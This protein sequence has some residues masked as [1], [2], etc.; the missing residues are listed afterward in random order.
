MSLSKLFKLT[1]H[2]P[3][4]FVKPCSWPQLGER[5][6]QTDDNPVYQIPR[7]L[8]THYLS[9]FD[10]D[11][12]FTTEE[13]FSALELDGIIAFRFNETML[14][15]QLR[16]PYDPFAVHAA[17]YLYNFTVDFSPHHTDLPLSC[18]VCNL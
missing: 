15:A 5:T 12:C 3:A 4:G 14:C 8:Q 10:G 16:H 6:E 13:R 11:Y 2:F 1:Q 18:Q 17:E 7:D 9:M